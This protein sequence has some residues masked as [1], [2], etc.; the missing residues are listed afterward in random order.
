MEI[1]HSTECIN[2]KK[3]VTNIKPTSIAIGENEN[4]G[5][6]LV[7][8]HFSKEDADN[9]RKLTADVHEQR[10]ILSVDNQAIYSGFLNAPLSRNKFTIT[11]N[12]VER[13]RRT[14]ALFHGS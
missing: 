1:I 2:Y 10:I 13:A 7:E 3:Q 8:I 12:S 5:V 14:A 6:Y 11:A 4:I 9:L